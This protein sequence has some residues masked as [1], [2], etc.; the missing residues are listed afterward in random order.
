MKQPT[1]HTVNKSNPTQVSHPPPAVRRAIAIVAVAAITLVPTALL[2]NRLVAK[3]AVT[4][5]TS[6]T[7]QPRA[8]TIDRSAS[9][10]APPP[11]TEFEQ[12]RVV[13]SCGLVCDPDLGA[14]WQQM[15]RAVDSDSRRALVA[16]TIR[17]TLQAIDEAVAAAAPALP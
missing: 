8:T 16:E 2:A 3:R 12:L 13:A 17:T 6:F 15:I 1:P 7:E 10:A 9:Y 5:Q 14:L 4:K 11:T